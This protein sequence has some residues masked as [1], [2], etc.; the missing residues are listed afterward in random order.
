MLRPGG[1]VVA[2]GNIQAT[3]SLGFMDLFLREKMY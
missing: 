3:F 2:F 1:Q